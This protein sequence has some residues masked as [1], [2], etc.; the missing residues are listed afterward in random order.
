R[1]VCVLVVVEQLLVPELADDDS[2]SNLPLVAG[3]LVERH[4]RRRIVRAAAEGDALNA[5]GVEARLLTFN[6]L[7]EGGRDV[8]AFH[9]STDGIAHALLDILRPEGMAGLVRVA[10]E[11]VSVLLS[12]EEG[13]VVD[14]HRQRDLRAQDEEPL[15]DAARDD[16]AAREEGIVAP[17]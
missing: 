13:L 2:L 8:D 9:L 4:S 10:V 15:L 11:K 14:A 3:Q 16:R 5:Y 1:G 7:E 6:R 17:S 12:D